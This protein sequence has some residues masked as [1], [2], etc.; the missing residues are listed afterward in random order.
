MSIVF[1]ARTQRKNERFNI[2]RKNKEKEIDGPP[3][4]E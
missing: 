3:S 2:D 1:E 4:T